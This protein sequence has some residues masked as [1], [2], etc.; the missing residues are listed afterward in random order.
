M[1]KAIIHGKGFIIEW[2][3]WKPQKF[4]PSNVLPWKY[5]APVSALSS[6]CINVFSGFMHSML[7]YRIRG[8][9][10]STKF[11]LY[12]KLTR[13][14]RLYFRWPHSLVII[15][16]ITYSKFLAVFTYDNQALA[17]Y[18]ITTDATAHSEDNGRHLKNMC[19]GLATLIVVNRQNFVD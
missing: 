2:K 11:S 18:V 19:S 6:K 5:W 17:I 14:S 10:C 15:T 1:H 7:F 4:S 3:P 13:F 9:F 12:S 16:W 8:N